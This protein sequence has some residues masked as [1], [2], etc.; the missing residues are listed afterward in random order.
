MQKD[1]MTAIDFQN[2]Y[3]SEAACL[4]SKSFGN[5]TF[6]MNKSLCDD[7]HDPVW[8]ILWLLLPEVRRGLH[9]RLLQSNSSALHSN[10]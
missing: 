3:S 5:A 6:G 2:H 1:S 9:L 4:D 8:N 10:L 7:K